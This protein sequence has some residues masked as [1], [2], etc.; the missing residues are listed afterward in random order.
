[1]PAVSG[2]SERVTQI[3]TNLLSNAHKYT[4]RGGAITISATQEEGD[5]RVSVR[6]EFDAV[7]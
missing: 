4:P 5:A 7:P 2:D 1:M 6:D 3:V